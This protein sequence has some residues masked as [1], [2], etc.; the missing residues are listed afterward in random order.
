VPL[1]SDLKRNIAFL[2]YIEEEHHFLGVKGRIE[3]VLV[4]VLKVVVVGFA[5]VGHLGSR[6]VG[7]WVSCFW[8]LFKWFTGSTS[9]L[10]LKIL[11]L[12]LVGMVVFRRRWKL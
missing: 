6:D 10:S 9:W 11:F 1:P 8:F 7:T 5:V 2:S 12:S 4:L 3:K